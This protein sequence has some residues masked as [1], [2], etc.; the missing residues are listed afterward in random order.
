M[1]CPAPS[2]D[3]ADLHAYVDGQLPAERRAAVEARLAADPALRGRVS[4]WRLQNELI[5]R[6]YPGAAVPPQLRPDRLLRTHRAGLRRL[7]A[8]AMLALTVGGGAGWLVHDRLPGQARPLDEVARLGTDLHRMAARGELPGALEPDRRQLEILLSQALAHE[9]QVPELDRLGLRLVGGRALPIAT[10]QYAA[11]L[12]YE[13]AAEARFTLYLVHPGP[14]PADGFEPV[15]A[16]GVP[17]VVWPYEEFH[18][19]LIG[20]APRERLLLISRAVQAE[21]DGDGAEPG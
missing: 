12:V 6:L 2:A 18:C 5:T 4:A 8:A 14:R 19:L 21:L 15:A 9:V 1:T 13:D 3:E 10:G 17:G 20:D 7:A 11:Q 16:A